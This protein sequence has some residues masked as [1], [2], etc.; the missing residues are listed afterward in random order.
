M[1]LDH[2]INCPECGVATKVALRDVAKQRTVQCP[3]GHN[4]VLEDA[5]GDGRKAQD[6]LD[7]F[8]RVLKRFGK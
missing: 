8:A 4:I 2:E 5:D 3:R 6:A 1:D 7:D